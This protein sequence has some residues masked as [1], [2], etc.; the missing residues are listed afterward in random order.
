GAHK[1]KGLGLKFLRHIER[2]KILLIMIDITS[3][4][5]QKDYKTLISELEKYSKVLSKKKRIIGFSKADLADDSTIRKIKKKKIDDNIP[6]VVFSAVSG[7]GI[8][9]LLDELWKQ[10][11]D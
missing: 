1:G 5:Y 7:F 3:E 11:Q 6:V 8:Q 4:N 2:T 10:L 9:E